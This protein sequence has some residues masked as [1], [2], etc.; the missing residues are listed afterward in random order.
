MA[1]YIEIE[2]DGK[3]LLKQIGACMKT[4][5]KRRGWIGVDL[6]GTLA[7]Y[8][9]WEGPYTIGAPVPRMV[10]FV[11]QLLKEGYD[12]R[13]F[14]ARI[15]GTDGSNINDVMEVIE[16]WC[17]SHLGTTL[18][19]TNVKDYGMRVL[20]DDRAVAVQRNTGVFLSP[21]LLEN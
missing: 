21:D 20:Y 9:D 18:P 6:D 2:Q 16:A 4:T 14:T 12:V 17:Y 10:E 11:K 1:A 8:H 3:V 13:I 7:E 5:I 15:A 19:I